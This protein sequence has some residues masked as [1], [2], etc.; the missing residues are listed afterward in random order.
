VKALRF[1]IESNIFIALAAVSLALATS[2]ELRIPL[3]FHAYLMVIFL[4]TLFDYNLHRFI[5]VSNEPEAAGSE[6]LRWSTEN[7][8]LLKFLILSS[9]TGLIISLFYIRKEILF[10]LAPM[11]VLSFFYS[12]RFPGQQKNAFRLF[13]IPGI[14]TFLIALVWS[15]ATV[16]IPFLQSGYSSG[17]T[18]VMLIFSERFTFIFAIAIPFDIRDMKPDEQAGIRTIP[19]TFGEKRSMQVSNFAMFISLSIAFIHYFSQNMPFVL[20]G[21][22]VSIA[23]TLIFINSRKLKSYPLYYHGILDGSIILHGLFIFLGFLLINC[24]IL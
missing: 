5:E 10:V 7:R 24:L 21:Y 3:Q 11:A 15:S 19:V 12:I 1:L 8:A 16:V 2:A 22:F 18:P 23:F 17:F 13:R 9:A 6:K 4:A 20:I 14:K